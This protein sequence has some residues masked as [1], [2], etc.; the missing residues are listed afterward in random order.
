MKNI[1]PLVSVII[2]AYNTADLTLKTVQSVLDQTYPNIEIIVVDDGSTDSTRS[3]LTSTFGSRIKY[4]YKENGGACS[5]R[6]AGIRLAQG[7]YIG[8][9]DCD[10][11]YLPTKIEKCVEFL[12]KKPDY[13]FVHT[14]AYFI[15]E[16][17]RVIREH[18]HSR[19]KHTG[20]IKDKLIIS[21]FVCNSTVL[22]R[23]ECFD[24]AGL[25]NE[26]IFPPADWDMWLRLSEYF[27]LG[28]LRE[29]L[30]QYRVISNWCFRNLERTHRETQQVIDNFFDRNP[31][32]PN[33][34]KH[35]AY[36]RFHL[37]MVFYYLVQHNRQ[38]IQEQFKLALEHG[39]L[40]IKTISI[41][42]YYWLAPRDLERK[43]ARFYFFQ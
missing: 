33:Q 20:F 15:D 27:R 2:P 43:I 6:N 41:L 5:A 3:K 22:A 37:S 30:T 40:N 24:K 34:I 39:P 28:Y 32:I 31:E 14:G 13:G 9:L 29:P 16:N 19:S 4:I 38:A 1:C 18:S 17:D 35:R 26:D 42:I 23:K 21:N 11:V 10:D 12:E 25:F 36:A 7:Q 8:L